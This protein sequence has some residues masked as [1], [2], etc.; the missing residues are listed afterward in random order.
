MTAASKSAPVWVH[1]TRPQTTRMQASPSFDVVVDRLPQEKPALLEPLAAHPAARTAELLAPQG[2]SPSRGCDVAVVERTSGRTV[3]FAT[4]LH[5]QGSTFQEYTRLADAALEK[6][7]FLTRVYVAPDAPN[8]TLPV[9]LYAGLRQ[10]RGWGLTT[11]GV[12]MADDQTPLAPRYGFTPLASVPRMDVAGTGAFRAKAQR[13]DILLH[14][15]SEEAA[16]A[17]QPL[18]PV[19][20]VTEIRETIETDF[21]DRVRQAHFFQAVETGTLTREQYTYVLTQLHQFVRYTTRLLGRCVA[22]SNESA[23]RNHFIHHLTGEINHEVIIERDLEHLGED[24]QYVKDAAQP[25]AATR[26]FMCTQESAIGFYGDPVLMLAA[27]LAAEGVS[28]NL[29]SPMVEKLQALV[30]SWGVKEPQ[31]AMRFISSHIE[32]DGGDDGHWQGNLMMLSHYLRTELQ[33]R[34]FLSLLHVSVDA[35]LRQYDSYV[36]DV[37]LW[38]ARPQ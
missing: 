9:L 5:S 28:G 18:D 21:L 38:S 19:F 7:A 10:A 14:K 2:V 25:N 20:L 6:A 16:A 34:R 33:L 31:K 35:V 1:R 8:G 12:L 23:M 17:G 3:A 30:G 15:T 4:V 37:A 36:G 26:Q 32:F 27:P 13:L 24:S 22:L 11:V 29:D